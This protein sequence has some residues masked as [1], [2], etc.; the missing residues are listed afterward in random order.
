MINI[1]EECEIKSYGKSL[2]FNCDGDFASQST[3]LNE[4]QDGLQFI[5]N[6]ENDSLVQGIFSLK[7]LSLFTKCTNLCNQIQLFIK[8]D[9]PLIIQYSIASLG[10]IKLCLAPK[11]N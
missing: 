2:L 9:Y 4:T 3:I 5:N 10:I 11:V 8:N 7:Y 1:G 6:C